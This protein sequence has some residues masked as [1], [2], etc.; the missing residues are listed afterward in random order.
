M[1]RT[2]SL[3]NSRGGALH[4]MWR[5]LRRTNEPRPTGCSQ[6]AISRT[7][8]S[9]TPLSREGRKYDVS[10][11]PMRRSTLSSVALSPKGRGTRVHPWRGGSGSGRDDVGKGG[12]WSVRGMLRN[13]GNRKVHGHAADMVLRLASNIK[14]L[15][16]SGLCQLCIRS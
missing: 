12:T 16:V 3:S 4:P 5:Y 7:Y 2:R 8:M 11:S 1:V 13:A 9:F 10:V 6:R 15:F 14:A